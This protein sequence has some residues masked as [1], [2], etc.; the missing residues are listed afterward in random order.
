MLFWISAAVLTFLTILTVIV[1]LARRVEGQED[2]IEFDKAIYHARV[3]E[4][5][6]DRAL[7]RIT[8]HEAKLALAE[9][10]R[11]LIT[12]AE[13]QVRA[14][15]PVSRMSRNV[16]MVLALILIPGAALVFYL[17]YGSP[18]MSDQTLASRMNAAPEN[19]S[20][21]ELVARAEAHLIENPDDA[22]G[23]A[24]VAPVYARLGRY[25]EAVRAW[26][27][28]YRLAPET[29]EIRSTL[30]EAML[31]VSNGVVTDAAQK[32][33]QEELAVNIASAKARFYL[34]MALGQEGKH[35]DAVDAWDEL[36]A[37]GTNQS[38]WMEAALEFRR[39]SAEEIG[40]TSVANIPL[41]EDGPGNP[42]REDVAA[43][44][45]MTSE[46]R[47]E[48]INTMVA[49]LAE[50]LAEDP[51]NKASWQRLIR[52]Y[53]VLGR[54][55]EAAA[56]I[57]TAEETHGDDSEFMVALDGFRKMLASSVGT[58]ENTQ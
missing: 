21:E 15:S 32:L 18:G 46:D 53:I 27:N 44:S 43:A 35:E 5:E 40:D 58:Q 56:A 34:A 24:V 2:E 10:G 39:R 30:A 23:W 8:D 3:A 20:I 49:G 9:E 19:Q 50:K 45:E 52:S 31:N 14:K 36:I 16:A 48:M 54:N 22:R 4:I 17:N 13:G 41:A 11:K 1:P 38:P 26:A 57:A 29:P 7:G 37:G 28:V 51:S 42:T 6:N 12:L 33:F 55:E 25:E 47:R